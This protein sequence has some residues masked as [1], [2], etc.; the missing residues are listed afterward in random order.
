MIEPVVLTL[1][2]AAM[3]AAAVYD[4]AT[5][6]IPNWISLFLVALFPIAAIGA[7]FSWAEVGIHFA[8]GFV[9][10]LVGMGLFAS[11]VIGGGDAKLFA[12][13]ALL[14]GAAD[15]AP[16]ILAVA[17][18]GG[19]LGCVLLGVRW[20]ATTYDVYGRLSWLSHIAKQGAGIPYGIAIA[21]GG[22]FV[23]PATRLFMIA[24][25]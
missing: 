15:F 13:I 16:Y 3:I 8:V 17:L 2:G 25:H 7:D 14:V 23:L 22:L 19:A 18:A 5:L 10:L 21:V 11:G 20:A 24:P 12:A 1:I 9:A 4:A 6:T